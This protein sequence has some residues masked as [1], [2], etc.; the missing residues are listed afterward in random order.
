MISHK[1]KCIFVHIPKTAG[2]SIENALRDKRVP[3]EGGST[4][5]GAL[6]YKK[7]FPEK[8][9]K[10][11]KFS[12]IRNPWA[13][14]VSGFFYFKKGGNGGLQDRQKGKLFGS[15]F[16]SFVRNINTFNK[17]EDPHFLLPQWKYIYIDG[18]LEIDYLLRFEHIKKD[19]NSLRQKLG[20]PL[21]NLYKTRQTPHKHYTEYYDDETRKI[22]AERYA[23]D[24]EYLGYKF[25]E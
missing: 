23:K 5:F 16:K 7:R 2:T 8:Y 11:L 4:H 9:K 15:D 19:Y 10:Y 3:F 25:G 21:K 17:I 22:V 14:L 6:Y 13:R 1:Y 18:S 24:I 20:L 12:I